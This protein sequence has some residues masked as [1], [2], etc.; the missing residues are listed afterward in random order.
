MLNGFR[1]EYRPLPQQPVISYKHT[2]REALEYRPQDSVVSTRETSLTPKG[3]NEYQYL[4]R[5]Q[6]SCSIGSIKSF[7]LERVGDSIRYN[8]KCM[9]IPIRAVL[10]ESI[11]PCS[12]LWYL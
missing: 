2:C 11:D 12:F 9:R 5:H 1:L 8:Y 7:K 4:D 6:V 3:N 10:R